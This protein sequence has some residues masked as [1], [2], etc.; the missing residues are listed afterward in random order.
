MAD[1]GANASPATGTGYASLLKAATLDGVIAPTPAMVA[2]VEAATYRT[3]GIEKAG[4]ASVAKAT[5]RAS[6]LPSRS[7]GAA[8]AGAP[9]IA[10][11]GGSLA[12]A[13]DA[14][15]TARG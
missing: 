10:D 8:V 7:A 12:Y 2:V 11:A 4:A 13:T 1:G 5:S 6:S 3:L 14:E 9:R 15:A